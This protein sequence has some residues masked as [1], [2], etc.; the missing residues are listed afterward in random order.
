MNVLFLGCGWATSMHSRTLR[1]IGGVRLLYASRDAARAD[2][3]RRRFNGA[4]AFGSYDAGLAD[5]SVDAVI[6]ATPTVTH[7]AL[8]LRALQAGRHVI[9]EKPAFMRSTDVAAVRDAASRATKTVLVAEN[10]FYKPLTTH[11]RNA[12]RAGRLGDVRF[13]SVN[14]TKRQVAQGWREDPATAGGGALFEG[15]VHWVSFMANI[16]LD[17]AGVRAWR[18]GTAGAIDVSTLSVFEYANG[19]VGTLAHSWELPAPFGG[20]RL[21]KIQGTRGAI[22]FESNGLG[23]V[24]SGDARSLG[25]PVL[26]GDFLG[27]RAMFRD[28]LQALRSG[29]QAQFTLELAERDLSLLEQAASSMNTAAAARHHHSW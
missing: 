3:Y 6:V 10:Y 7:G 29:G 9:V 26:R 18:V 13:V 17:V 20:I 16:G 23:Y 15:G 25:L 21:S 4:R 24:G 8:A 28:F 22:T 5:A 12:V 2:A 27:Y 19:A 1:R 11:L 14:A